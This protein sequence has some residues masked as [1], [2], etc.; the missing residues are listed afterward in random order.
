MKRVNPDLWAGLIFIVTGGAAVVLSRSYEMGTAARMGPAYFPTVLG[1]LLV[2]LG[3]MVAV[4]SF[5]QAGGEAP[6]F[7]FRPLLLILGSVVLFGVLLERL[8]LI[9]TTILTVVLSRW[10]SREFKGKEVAILVAV[11]SLLAAGLFVYGLSLPL[12]LW[13][14]LWRY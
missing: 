2:L 5:W 13:P 12:R 4:R 7:H 14:E 10:A 1:L 11:L 9:P 3:L 8:G 6:R